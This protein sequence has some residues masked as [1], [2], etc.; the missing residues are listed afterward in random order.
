MWTRSLSQNLNILRPKIAFK[1]K[2]KVF[3]IIFSGLSS[4]Q[5]KPTFAEGETIGIR[6][7]KMKENRNLENVEKYG[8]RLD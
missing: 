7:Q 4:T 3:L 5:I 6:D 1:M 8:E 2:W